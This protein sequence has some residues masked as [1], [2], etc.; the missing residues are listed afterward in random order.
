MLT[1]EEIKE[2]KR[3][4]KE[5]MGIDLTDAEAEDQGSRLVT[6]FEL[7]IEVDRKKKQKEKEETK[8]S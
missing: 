6:L 1:D 7:L 2:F 5:T 8:K 4:A 3:I